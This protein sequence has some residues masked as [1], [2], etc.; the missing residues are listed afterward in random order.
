MIVIL[1]FYTAYVAAQLH[2]AGK[3]L[4]ATFGV[5]PLWGIV[6]GVTIVVFYT[7]MGGFLAVAWTDLI[8][9]LLMTAVAVVL[10]VVGLIHVGGPAA[11]LEK[12]AVRGPDFLT[13]SGGKVGH[14]M[15]PLWAAML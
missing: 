3:I 7:L 11:L 4:N 2:G 6:I 12:L 13:M 15:S 8:Q 14:A 9:G 5:E 10:P 1:F